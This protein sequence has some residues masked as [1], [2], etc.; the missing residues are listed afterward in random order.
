MNLL[1][2]FPEIHDFFLQEQF[3]DFQLKGLQKFIDNKY[4]DQDLNKAA[5]RLIKLELIKYNMVDAND[6]KKNLSRQSFIES[7][8]EFP[9]KE[10]IKM[11]DIQQI[12]EYI[13]WPI[14]R[15]K[16][17]LSRN[18]IERA[19]NE[20][21]SEKELEILFPHFEKALSLKQRKLLRE[22][23]LNTSVNKT[24]SKSTNG[25]GVYGYIQNFKGPIKLIYIRFKT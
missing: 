23:Y 14:S 22:K 7:H 6:R 19:M 10:I 8:K 4:T 13:D 16:V 11:L 25:S 18:N 21:L 12:C 9:I 24:Y 5:K 1:K 15:V 3:Y 20:F 2:S 17:I